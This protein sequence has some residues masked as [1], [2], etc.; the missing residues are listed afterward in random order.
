MLSISSAMLLLIFYGVCQ[1]FIARWGQSNVS[2]AEKV[3]QSA[4][5]Y[6]LSLAVYCTS[7]T[8]YGSIG[9]ASEQ[10]INHVA[11]YLGSTLTLILFT[12]LLK[13]MVRIKNVYHST[14]I[15][16]FISTRYNRSPLLA[17]LISILCLV[18]ITPYISIQLKSVIATFSLLV[19][20]SSSD[21]FFMSQIDL[22]IVFIMA[23][24]TILFGVRRLDPTER[25]PGM[26]VALAADSLFKLLVF[27]V[28]GLFICFVLFDGFSDIISKLSER[29]VSDSRF[30]GFFN[31]PETI[32]WFT[33]M[34]LGAIGIIAL[35]RQFH[36]G[37]V[38]CRDTKMLDR[39]RWLFPLYLFAI[40]LFVLPIAMAGM[41]LLPEGNNADLMLLQIPV[42]EN[43]TL[44]ASLI[45]LGGL[46]ASTGM[47]M[48]SAMT[49]S[50]MTTNHLLLPIIEKLSPMQ[51]LRRHLLYIRWVVVFSILFLSLYYYR[52]IGDSELIVRIGSISFVAV[53]QLLPALIGGLLWKKGN[54]Y[55]A[56]AGLI[57]GTII[58][59]FTLMLP[60]VIRSGW[61]QTDM[62]EFGLFGL[63]WLNPERLFLLV[64]DS[65]IAHSLI[66][67]LSINLVL[68]I[69][70]SEHFPISNKDH[71]NHTQ[72][73]MAIG[74]GVES[75]KATP[76][77]LTANITL[78]TKFELLVKL[79]SRYIPEQQA[80]DKMNLCC[81]QCNINERIMIDVLQLSQLRARAVSLLAGLIGMAAADKAL[82]SIH[83]FTKNEKNTL[84][85]SYAQLLAQSNLSPDELLSKVDF[86][87]E[88]QSL[89]E[90]HASLQEKTIQQLQVE[91]EQTQLAKQALDTLNQELESRV[92]QRTEQLT[93]SNGELH[94]TLVELKA[95]QT[96]LLEADKMASLGSLVAGVAHE[97]N[98][99]VG[100]VLTAMT[101]IE[102]EKDKF[103]ALYKE[104]KLTKKVMD[105]FMAILSETI[106]ISI[107]SIGNAVRLVNSFK[108]VAVDQTNEIPRQ[109]NVSQYVDSI[110]L[111]LKPELKKKP[112]Y[113]NVHCDENLVVTSYPGALSQIMNNLI[114][115][116]LIH[117]YKN[118]PKGEINLSIELIDGHLHLSYA[119]DG[120]GLTS[121]GADNIFEPFYTTSRG[122][123]GSGLGAHIVYN[124][125][126]QLLKGS[127]SINNKVDK[128]FA[129][130]IE[131]PLVENLLLSKT[132]T[133]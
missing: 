11:L 112:I 79:F 116:S 52:A 43:K 20:E 132:D 96:K 129:L 47:I 53:A 76:K 44:L 69:L 55:G 119:D 3:R 13:K 23:V 83:L 26:M 22:L 109:F 93:I 8:Y 128:G 78:K 118:Q 124:L 89:L 106:D 28:A 7:W 14:S 24:F 65:T 92:V 34:A 9:H 72:K 97:I 31:P 41:L 111:A 82:N 4:T 70:V 61:L 88:K 37:V 71:I 30:D 39:A 120:I 46:A 27:I 40:N 87:Q 95:T 59:Y 66:W 114:M 75:S 5:T 25:H 117:G 122:A 38:E 77:N 45:F 49:L 57:A 107:T 115:N 10:G 36:V 108:E 105:N 58:W 130:N 68:Y 99:P 127:I 62:L 81:L 113:V 131:F 126:T 6:T 56:V 84:S 125:V 110:L 103:N 48:I 85:V 64:I 12:P 29:A 91:T 60:S 104:Q 54:F 80:I 133:S 42:S 100:I 63:E 35:P 18:G 15:A 33:S 73:I 51:F 50:T 86:Y 16:D 98:T 123:G 101:S 67:S 74:R 17:A 21:G 94:T 121:E 1:Y 19:N 90:D 2:K 102:Y 32:N